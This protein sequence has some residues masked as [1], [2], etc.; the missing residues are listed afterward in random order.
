MLR[1]D[2]DDRASN[3][4]AFIE[5]IGRNTFSR[6]AQAQELSLSLGRQR[7]TLARELVHS[8]AAN[9]TLDHL[10][11]VQHGKFEGHP[12]R[13]VTQNPVPHELHLD[14]HIKENYEIENP[15]RWRQKGRSHQQSALRGRPMEILPSDSQGTKIP[16]EIEVCDR[17]SVRSDC[18]AT[19]L[20]SRD[21]ADAATSAR[22]DQ[23]SAAVSRLRP[24]HLVWTNYYPSRLDKL[25]E[26]PM[27]FDHCYRDGRKLD[28]SARHRSF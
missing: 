8:G 11:L 25:N 9:F 17:V 26:S 5:D 28:R 23:G 3:Y 10:A 2:P 12:L 19:V 16:G 14:P 1:E 4:G 24:T 20:Q 6:F 7:S 13:I 22:R 21:L 18:S 27:Q 15:A